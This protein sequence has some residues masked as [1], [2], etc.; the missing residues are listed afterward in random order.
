MKERR[1]L[2][3]FVGALV[4]LSADCRRVVTPRTRRYLLGMVCRERFSSANAPIR[5]AGL[6]PASRSASILIGRCQIAL[7]LLS[8]DFQELM[9]GGKRNF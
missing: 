5:G 1:Q 8:A 2:F 7:Q 6:I 4:V 3:A 9:N